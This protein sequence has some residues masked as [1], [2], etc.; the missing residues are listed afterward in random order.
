MSLHFIGDVLG[1]HEISA[2]EAKPGV[3]SLEMYFWRTSV[4]CMVKKCSKL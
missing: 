2:A 4:A 3:M 1:C